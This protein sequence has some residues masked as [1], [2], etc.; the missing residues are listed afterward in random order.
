[1]AIDFEDT[2]FGFNRRREFVETLVAAKRKVTE[3]VQH[4]GRESADSLH[5]LLRALDDVINDP[6]FQPNAAQTRSISK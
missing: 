1:M 2:S 4:P 6:A 5:R 3:R